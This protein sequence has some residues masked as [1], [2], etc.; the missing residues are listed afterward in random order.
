MRLEN[1][2]VIAPGIGEK[3]EQRLWREGIKTW[4]GFEGNDV[5]GAATHEKAASFLDKARKNLSV[6][7]APFFAHHL[8]SGGSWRMYEDF[9]DD[10][11]FFDIETTGLD[12]ERNVVTTISVYHEGETTTLVRGKDLSAERIES[13]LGAASVMVS[14]NGKRFDI[15][16]LKHNF[17]ISINTPH[18]DLYYLCK[19]LG[20]SGGL[21]RIEQ[22]LGVD[23]DL[24]DIDGREAVRLWKQYQRGEDEALETLIHYN[25]L[26]V[27]NLEDVLDLVHAKLRADVFEPH[28][29]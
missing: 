15:P 19:R 6:G 16:F 25:Q 23:R 10:A 20:L 5:V 11:A 9:R 28:V 12:R 17:D 29:A 8:P 18:I 26:D 22:E 7:N 1:S 24:E 13:L 14:F 3:T 4:D 27:V 21:K 2:F